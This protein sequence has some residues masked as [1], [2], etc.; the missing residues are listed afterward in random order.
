MQGEER[1]SRETCTRDKEATQ[2]LLSLS[3]HLIRFHFRF[4][5]IRFSTI[6]IKSNQITYHSIFVHS[7]CVTDR[8]S[9]KKAKSSQSQ[10]ARPHAREEKREKKEKKR[11]K[12][13]KKSEKYIRFRGLDRWVG[14]FLR[15]RNLATS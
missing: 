7:I 15:F 2:K 14:S 10:L 1:G 11:E 3:S 5:T 12:K 4:S 9:G 6:Q 8:S 13:R